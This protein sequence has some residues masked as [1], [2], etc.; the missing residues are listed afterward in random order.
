MQVSCSIP[1]GTQTLI[2][3]Y[4]HS[5]TLSL[6]TLAWLNRSPEEQC[7]TTWAKQESPEK[8]AADADVAE[9]HT[10]LKDNGTNT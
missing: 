3:G 2:H 1:E 8:C 10:H 7:P 9:G 4:R 6:H 5:R